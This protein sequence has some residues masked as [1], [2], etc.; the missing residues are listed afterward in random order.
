MR[1]DRLAEQMTRAQA[2]G[3]KTLAEEAYP[4]ERYANDLSFKEAARRTA[5]L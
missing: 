1:S 4:P 2:L 5:R 3:L